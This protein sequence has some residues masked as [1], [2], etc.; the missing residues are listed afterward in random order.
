M[1][2]NNPLSLQILT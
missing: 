2:S 1:S